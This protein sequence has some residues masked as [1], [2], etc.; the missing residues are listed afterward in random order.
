L[1][2][3]SNASIALYRND[4]ENNDEVTATAVAAA[5]EA[6]MAMV[7]ILGASPVKTLSEAFALLSSWQ[8]T[9]PYRGGGRDGVACVNFSD[10]ANGTDG[11][12]ALAKKGKHE[13]KEI[14]CFAC[15]STS[16][17]TYVTTCPKHA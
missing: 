7:F 14:S 4:G 16:Q 10:E 5:A 15:S 1:R 12:V 9:E 17:L 2:S 8:D 6:E 3:L 13:K 11:G